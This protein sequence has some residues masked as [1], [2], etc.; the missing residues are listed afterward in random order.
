[1]LKQLFR[2]SVC[3]ILILLCLA[4]A[5]A[6]EQPLRLNLELDPGPST[7]RD[8]DYAYRKVSHERTV[9]V[10]LY[11]FQQPTG[12]EEEQP[13]I[14]KER[15]SLGGFFKQHI[16]QVNNSMGQDGDP[17]IRIVT[18]QNAFTSTAMNRGN[19]I[20][21]ARM[22]GLTVPVGRLT[23]GGGYLWG[24]KNPAL[25]QKTDGIFGGIGYD[26]GRAGFQLS[27]IDSGRAPNSKEIDGTDVKYRSVMFGTSF[28]VSQ[29]M[30]LTATAQYRDV[31][32]AG[33]IDDRGAVFTLG[34]R[35]K[36]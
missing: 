27:Y 20:D 15:K 35:W 34:T 16:Q 4:P 28:Q 14:Q 23:F 10:M 33:A 5:F 26:T 36:F 12:Q 32:N 9:S 19:N 29:R 13:A 6:D 3:P 1:M 8:R 7:F 11:G 2:A 21:P 17:G 24:E 30:S 31:R 22:A 25:M 18:G